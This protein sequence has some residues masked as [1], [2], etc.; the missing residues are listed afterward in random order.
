MG[1]NFVERTFNFSISVINYCELLPNSF[2]G[3]NIA[4]QLVR[5]G[6][7]VGANFRAAKRAR[8][9]KEFLPK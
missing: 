8:S 3:K 1:F 2:A 6:T 7:S 9:D 5:S 4:C